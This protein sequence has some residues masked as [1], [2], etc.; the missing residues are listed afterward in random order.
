M[1]KNGK[2]AQKEANMDSK[3]KTN[4]HIIIKIDKIDFKKKMITYLKKA[5]L[6]K[7]VEDKKI[8]QKNKNQIVKEAD[9][10]ILMIIVQLLQKN[11]MSV[12]PVW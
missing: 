3:N 12:L 2:T 6:W 9:Q 7:L 1:K 8:S 5:L 10:E 11:P 4:K